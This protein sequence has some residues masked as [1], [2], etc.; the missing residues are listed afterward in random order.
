MPRHRALVFCAVAI[1]AVAVGMMLV[2][3]WFD[4][5]PAPRPPAEP[6][7]TPA[8]RE[9]RQPMLPAAP[10]D[11]TEAARVTVA[12]PE[13]AEEMARQRLYESFGVRRVGATGGGLRVVVTAGETKIVGHE[14]FFVEMRETWGDEKAW[15]E[16]VRRVRP[17][18]GVTRTDVDGIAR[19]D[20]QHIHGVT[21]WVM[22]NQTMLWRATGPIYWKAVSV[23]FAF[24]PVV[25]R[26]TVHDANG[27][28][29]AGA[30]I[31]AVPEPKPGRKE[32]A[33][34]TYV[35]VSDEL[36]KFELTGLPHD[37]LRVTC[38]GNETFG[39]AE[40]QRTVEP[41]RS[42]Q[43]SVR[44]GG[45]PG[46]RWWRGRVVDENGV[47]VVG[48]N[49]IRL[50]HA[51]GER[52]VVASQSD[53]TFAVQLWP[54]VWRARVGRATKAQSEKPL[55]VVVEARDVERDVVLPGRQVLL[56]LAAADPSVH[57]VHTLEWL[58]LTRETEP[59]ES[60]PA[61]GKA[62]TLQSVMGRV[63]SGA[64][65]PRGEPM[66]GGR[67]FKWNGAEYYGWSGLPDDLYTLVIWGN[68]EVV[69]MPEAGMP[70]D[71]RL[72]SP[73]IVDVLLRRA[74]AK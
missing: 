56:R 11:A 1:V 65:T 59:T 41:T 43:V 40:E 33:F 48:P 7:P 36:G 16:V 3:G 58:A 42:K 32:Q 38:L 60:Q 37:S 24:G 39:H 64:P 69:G 19:F 61:A 44:F 53:G 5:E 62:E 14:A 70:I 67:L 13:L 71:T 47:L 63:K 12:D 72:M 17:I 20:G 57:L 68:Y 10:A 50:E 34:T 9:P 2:F 27:L 26:G 21:A 55:E 74:E 6:T 35:G 73:T 18:E 66:V 45:T 52:R 15:L 23:E 51:D 8:A 25:L 31:T 28:P 49:E 4:L 54:G 30:V 46:V 22:H 29:R